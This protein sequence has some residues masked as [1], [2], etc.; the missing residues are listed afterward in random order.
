MK[1]VCWYGIHDVRT[2]NVPDPIMVSPHDMI[3]R[4]T[5]SSVCGSDLHLYDGMVVTMR[6][7]DI[8]GHEFMGEVVE[9]GKEVRKVKPGDR[10]IVPSLVACGHCTFCAEGN[11]SWCDN[12]N[13][14][15]WVLE[16]MY[17][18]SPAGFFGYSHGFGGYAGCFAEYMRV[19]MA[20]VGAFLAPQGYTDEQLLFASDAAPTGY[21]AADY[22]NIKPGQTVAV[23]GCGAV[24]L[25]AMK[26][27]WLLGAGRV[28]AIDRVPARLRMAQEQCGAEVLN[29]EQVDVVEALIE[30]TGSRGPDACI[31]AV[32]MEADQGGLEGAYDRVKQTLRL[33]T[34]RPYA[35]R[36]AIRACRKGG[37]VVVMG[38]YA[39]FV[40]K[41]P[42]GA[43]FNKG[44]TIRAGQQHG[45]HYIPQLLR[46]VEEGRLDMTFPITHRFSLDQAKMA[47][48]LS[49]KRE[50]S[51]VRA[52]FFH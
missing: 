38:V 36:E 13:P 26:S 21:Q 19:P 46:Y 34:D 49:R 15:A 39:G 11:T 29:F 42:I 4:V 24:G 41:F 44:L 22:A 1:A 12:S 18:Q 9:V 28:I 8:I 17:G 40:D 7:G 52:V 48:E 23:W 47:F 5:S 6:E 3:L 45:H 31:E 35:L 27:A 16:K 30:M 32:G 2:E 20:D 43:V 33:E 14:N 37:T 50:D 51:L 25:F 10:V